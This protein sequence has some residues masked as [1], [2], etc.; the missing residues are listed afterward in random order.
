[1]EQ[2]ETE[3]YINDALLGKISREQNNCAQI[4]AYYN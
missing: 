4:R 2:N 1:M 3:N